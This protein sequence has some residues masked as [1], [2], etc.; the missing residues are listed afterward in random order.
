MVKK[1]KTKKK[2]SLKPSRWWHW[3]LIILCFLIALVY[4]AR[5]WNPIVFPP[6][7]DPIIGVSF[8]EKRSKELGLDWKANFTALLDDMHI[9][10]FRLMSYWDLHEPVRGQ[11]DFSTLDWQIEEAGKRG[12]TVSLALGQRQPRWPECHQPAW[13]NDLQ[14]DDWRQALYDYVEVVV[15]RYENN[16]TVINWQLENEA[17]NEWFGLCGKPD[18]ERIHAEYKLVDKLSDK[19]IWMSLS[20]QHGYPVTTPVPDKYGYSVYRVVW[21]EKTWP[22]KGYLIYPTPIWYHKLRGAIIK[23]YTGRDIYIHELQLEP[24][25]P[26]DTKEM[27]VADQEI[28]MS[29]ARIKDNVLFAREIGAREIYTWGSEWWYWRMVNGDPSIWNTV[30]DTFADAQ[31]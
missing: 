10:T 17:V 4:S 21:S 20:D 16:P 13:T 5:W 29:E 26:V 18:R 14:G 19:P 28:S 11:Y 15:K 9:S 27:T 23:A 6:V 25:G 7:K 30:K 2:R 31:E 3:T 1:Q 22:Y 24:W 12:A 8:S